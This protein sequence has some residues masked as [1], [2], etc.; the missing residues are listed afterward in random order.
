MADKPIMNRILKIVLP[1]TLPS[2]RSA[3]PASADDALTANSG[4]VVQND[5]TTRPTTS[6]DMPIVVARRDAPRTSNSAPMSNNTRPMMNRTM[7]CVFMV[8][9]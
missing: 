8:A 1:A 6:G 3:S 9:E 7:V 2:A 4:E 5:T